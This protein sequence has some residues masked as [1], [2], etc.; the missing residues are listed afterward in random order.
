MTDKEFWKLIGL[1]SNDGEEPELG[2][3][4]DALEKS[5]DEELIGF[6]EQFDFHHRQSYNWDLWGAAY[7][8]NGGCSD[9]GFDYFR[10]WLIA[11]GQQVFEAGLADPDSL[12][13]HANEEF[14]E[15]EEIL[16]LACRIYRERTDD[17]MPLT[18]FE[19]PELGESWDFDDDDEMKK[20]YPRLF[21]RFCD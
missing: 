5:S 6:Q 20:R 19:L 12:A 15:C 10:A 13:E 21:A 3:L 7:L 14:S 1:I 11:Q 17:N 16:V 9:D 2:P 18:D 8:I 4:I